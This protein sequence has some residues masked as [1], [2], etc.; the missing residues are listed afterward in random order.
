MKSTINEAGNRLDATNSRL[1]LSEEQISDV[2]DNIM[3]SN[4][5][6]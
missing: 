5:T 2:E 1:E 3:E 4:E 6:E